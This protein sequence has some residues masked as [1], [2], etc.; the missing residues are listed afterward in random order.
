MRQNDNPPLTLNPNQAGPLRTNSFQPNPWQPNARQS[1][2]TGSNLLALRFQDQQLGG[3]L[4]PLP[5]QPNSSSC[6]DVMKFSAV[7]DAALKATSCFLRIIRIEAC[8]SD[9]GR[10]DHPHHCRVRIGSATSAVAAELIQ[11]F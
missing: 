11:L 9:L 10:T 4:Q 7:A 3:A 8:R 1:L 5:L 6:F 2:P